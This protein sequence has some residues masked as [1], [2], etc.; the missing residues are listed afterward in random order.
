LVGVPSFIDGDFT[1]G[2][3]MDPNLIYDIGSHK[4]EDSEFYLKKGFRVVAVEA[5]P[6]LCDITRHRLRKFIRT[7]QLTIVNAAIAN[8]DGPVNFY[9]NQRISAWGTV[10]EEW[11]RRN[12][13]LG[14]ESISITVEGV[15][16]CRI[17]NEY[18]IPYY[19]KIDIEGN[20][21]LCLRALKSFTTR[22]KFVSFESSKTSW[23]ALREEFRILS[24]LGFSKFK[25]V[26]QLR[27]PKQVCPSP[28]REGRYV[29]HQFEPGSSGPFGEELPGHWLSMEEAIRAYQRVFLRY[30]LFGDEGKL[31][32]VPRLCNLSRLSGWYDTHAAL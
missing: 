5:L 1:H 2:T 21:L 23:Q 19:M 26:Q 32:R 15:D 31:N 9:A 25:L 4:G 16:I 7:G 30:W 29:A 20:D 6:D 28:A 12:E 27:V 24:A 11:K 13:R 10:S 14:K 17:L 18:G 22:P 3:T 8:Q